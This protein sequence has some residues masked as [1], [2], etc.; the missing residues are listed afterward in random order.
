MAERV[1]LSITCHGEVRLK[2][3]RARPDYG[4][5]VGQASPGEGARVGYVELKAPSKPIPPSPFLAEHDKEQ[6]Q[7]FQRLPNVLYC[8]GLQW[9]LFHFG[10]QAGETVE[11]SGGFGRRQRLRAAGDAFERLV[12][13]FLLWE[14][15]PFYTLDQ[16]IGVLAGLCRSLRAEVAE[17]IEMESQ[18]DPSRPFTRLAEDW[19]ELL[20]PTLDPGPRF[21]DAYAQTVTFALLLAR[22]AGVEF[23][24][25][26]PR[27]IAELLSKHHPLLGQALDALTHPGTIKNLTVLPTIIQVLTPIDWQHLMAGHRHAHIDLYETFLERYDPE[28]RKQSGAYY[29]PEPAAR[30]IAEF[31]DEVLKTRLNKRTGLADDSVTTLDPAMGTGTFLAS[32]TR[33]AAQ[34]LTHEHGEV[35]ALTHLKEL[36]RQR[37][38]GFE[39]S[40]APFAVAELRL[41][42]QL[43]ET[44]GA[45]VPEEHRRFLINTLDDPYYQHARLGAAYSEI[46][47]SRNHAN[48]VKSSEPVMVVLGNPPYIDRAKQ[49]DAAPW[50]EKR[51]NT[52]EADP[53]CLRPSMDEFREAGQGRLDYK[54]AGVSTYFWR[55]AT[56][57]VFD[58]HPQQPVGIVAFV[59]T[60]SYLTQAAFAGMRRYLR[61]TADEGWI[62]DLTPE[63]HQP[64]VATRLFPGVQQPICIGIFAR[65][66][67]PNPETPARIHHAQLTGSRA[68]KLADLTTDPGLRLSGERWRA[69]ATGWTSP[70]RPQETNWLA[71]PALGDLLPW[72]QSGVAPNRTWVYAP[73]HETLMARWNRLSSADPASKD[74]LFKAT[75]DRD[76]STQLS[77]LA[78]IHR[79][80]QAPDSVSV[81]FRSFDRQ[82]LIHDP[83]FVDR[84]RPALW[85]VRG[86]R[87]VFVVEQHANAI[88][89]GPALHFSA[90]VPD[91]DCFKGRGGRVLPL[92]RDP[93]HLAPN[94]AP[95]LLATLRDR[96]GAPVTAGD[97]LAYIAALVAHPGYTRKFSEQLRV[98]GVRVPLTSDA[99][100]WRSAAELGREIVWLHTFGERFSDPA[101]GRPPGPPRLPPARRPQVHVEIP[102]SPTRLPD[103][104]THDIDHGNAGQRLYVGHGIIDP[105]SP[106]V[107][108]YDIGGMRVVR[109]WFTARQATPRHKRRSS[110][111][112]DIRHD[113]WTPQFTDELIELLTVLTRL[114]DHEPSQA[115]LLQ[116]VCAGPQITVADLEEHG[117]LPP[118]PGCRKPPRGSG[119]GE[120]PLQ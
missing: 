53:L 54:L 5:D 41:H 71:H 64:G 13:E 51:R 29:T 74:H 70:F 59:S 8:N 25:R 105:V 108:A 61:A 104:I 78:P 90:L 4:I 45:E 114:I 46:A 26:T 85:D 113:R 102:D 43:K 27:Q 47:E 9:A 67:P 68:A 56:W 81:L 97:L 115:R 73:T 20:F 99:N 1:G 69:C 89:S 3:L 117:V 116:D 18:L 107:W 91:V 36:Y 30:F 50:I 17:I 35:H 12:T 63:G 84:P 39:R 76:T 6:W 7:K 88:S 110:P 31:V 32:V 62:I 100:L 60:S 112:D 94:L 77:G 33:T 98:P 19:R 14:P 22:E 75:T 44:Y 83:R 120:L 34:T 57:K 109:K 95:G 72:R 65:Y 49:R 119:Q 21:A 10:K 2:G 106:Q 66:G 118:D 48:A 28:L 86:E 55:W 103:H 82:Q 52:V 92:Y 79:E 15:D 58:A 93:D 24:G 42:Q 101:A 37:L 111:L 16:L 11:F 80:R 38:V 96:I 23:S 87:Q 40:A